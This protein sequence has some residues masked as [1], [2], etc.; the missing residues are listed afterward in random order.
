MTADQITIIGITLVLM[1]F[2]SVAIFNVR[3]FKNKSDFLFAENINADN[4]AVNI[5]ATFSSL[6][7]PFFFFLL[8]AA[9]FGYMLLI[10]LILQW[11]GH[12]YFLRLVEGLSIDPGHVGSIYRLIHHLSGSKAI[13]TAANIIVAI[14]TFFLLSVEL[15]LGS[16]VFAYFATNIP[17][18]SLIGF[19]ALA[20]IVSIYIISGGFR[21]VFLTD[22]WQ[23]ALIVV[24][25]ALALFSV[26]YSLSGKLGIS[27]GALS[28][29][30]LLKNPLLPGIV[31]FVFF[32]NSLAT[33]FTQACIQVS[34]WQRIA[35]AETFPEIKKGV[36]KAINRQFLLVWFAAIVIG[37]IALKLGKNI[38][39]VG[40]IANLVKG[41]GF[42]GEFL[43]YPL[44]FIGLVAALMSTADSHLISLMLSID[45]F[46][47]KWFEKSIFNRIKYGVQIW[48]G[49]VALIIGVSLVCEYIWFSSL[50]S[51]WRQ[52][53]TQ[54]MFAGYGQAALLFPL[55]RSII[56]RYPSSDTFTGGCMEP[57]N[58]IVV[59]TIILF[60]LV[61]YW[62]LQGT[63]LMN[64]IFWLSQLAPVIGLIIVA[65]ATPAVTITQEEAPNE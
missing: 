37:A 14:N 23:Y 1:V 38:D 6:A 42:I 45:D 53:I 64:G 49:A 47:G 61:V 35:S 58:K 8:Q 5:S 54:L 31:L 62:I 55:I 51:E 25:I 50:Q 10:L 32:L 40:D 20:I 56:I 3:L 43:V 22:R 12:K 19:V 27:G 59:T 24:G 18:A 41:T 21:L 30:E 57:T 34:S 2:C 7:G 28:I 44:L 11:L 29:I 17:N 48:F 9:N 16:A 33:T 13:A 36:E 65:F 60:A 4:I 63:A 46:T 52:K 26:F 15:I 39:N